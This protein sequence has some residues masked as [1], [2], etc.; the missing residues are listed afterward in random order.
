MSHWIAPDQGVLGELVHRHQ[1]ALLAKARKLCRDDQEARDLVQD[2]FERAFRKFHSFSPRTNERAWLMV[3]LGN[4]FVDRVKRQKVIQFEQLH[5]E[6]LANEP[7]CPP[8]LMVAPE[9]IHAL[10]AQL[11]ETLRQVIELKEFQELDYSEIA[12]RT[13]AKVGTVGSR[14]TR[15]REQLRGLLKAAMR[16]GQ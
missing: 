13:G 9:I 14:L 2:T 12:S 7:D 4:L 1:V 11:D 5:S 8:E 6:H 3:I 16:R 15:A 10:V